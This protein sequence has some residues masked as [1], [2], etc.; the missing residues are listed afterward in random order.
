MSSGPT[1]P[2]IPPSVS[3]ISGASAQAKIDQISVRIIAIPDAMRNRPSGSGT[4]RVDGVV[5]GQNP[6]GS[7][8]VKTDQGVVILAL[9]DKGTLPQ[10]LHI[11]VD[12]PAGRSAQQAMI[13]VTN[14]QTNSP[15]NSP[16]SSPPI[17]PST[18]TV[19]VNPPPPPT[20]GIPA[21]SSPR[22][23]IFA[24]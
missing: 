20:T 5:N 22:S 15:T 11:T 16:T 24:D 6:D 19:T 21:S 12:I 13:T 17:T 9:K 23:P 3:A 14:A 4:L 18:P 7:V 2:P 1:H 10:G 8:S